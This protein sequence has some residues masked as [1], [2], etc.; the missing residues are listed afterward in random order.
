MDATDGQE[1]S[2]SIFFLA[3]FV[4]LALIIAIILRDVLAVTPEPIDGIYAQPGKCFLLK[5]SFIYLSILARQWR[6]KRRKKKDG[7]TAEQSKGYGV[8][9]TNKEEDLEFVTAVPDNPQVSSL[10]SLPFLS[11]FNLVHK[12][13]CIHIVNLGP[14]A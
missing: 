5:R 4:F 12:T 1:G 3:S 14:V 6:S 8:R 13:M 7:G 9:S 2:I 11:V 10:T